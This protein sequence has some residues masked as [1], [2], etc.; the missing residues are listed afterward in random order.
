MDVVLVFARQQ[1]KRERIVG[2]PDYFWHNL[3]TQKELYQMA[4]GKI[5]RNMAVNYT[6][7]P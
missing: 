1:A 7:R 2:L 6:K 4:I 5:Y 3:P